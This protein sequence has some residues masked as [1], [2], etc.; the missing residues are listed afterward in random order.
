VSLPPKDAVVGIPVDPCA[1]EEKSNDYKGL[2]KGSSAHASE[3]VR[4][5]VSRSDMLPERLLVYN[6]L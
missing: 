6:K 5:S 4:Y 2:N 3:L 1:A